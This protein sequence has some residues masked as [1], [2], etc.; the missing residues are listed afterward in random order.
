M[1]SLSGMCDRCSLSQDLDRS[2]CDNNRTCPNCSANYTLRSFGGTTDADDVSMRIYLAHKSKIVYEGDQDWMPSDSNINMKTF[3]RGAISV[4]LNTSIGKALSQYGFLRMHPSA[5]A[6]MLETERWHLVETTRF[7]KE[8]VK[9]SAYHRFSYDMGNKL[10]AAYVHAVFPL[11][12]IRDTFGGEDPKEEKLGD[13]IE[14]IL[15]LFEVWDSVPDCIPVDLHGQN[16]INELRRGLDCSLINFCSIGDI[17]IMKN[18]K[19]NKRKGI[20][21]EIPKSI[22]GI[23]PHLDYYVPEEEGMEDDTVLSDLLDEA[24]EVHERDDGDEQDDDKQEEEDAEMVISSGG[25]EMDEEETKAGEPAEDEPMGEEKEEGP[26]AKRRRVAKLVESIPNEGVCLACGSTEHAMSECK[27]QEAVKRIND[28]FGEILANIKVNKQSFPKG[29]RSRTEKKAKERRA[30][31]DDTPDRVISLYPEEIQAF[32]ICADYQD[33]HWTALGTHTN[34]L[35][36][37]SHN[38][39]IN[40]ILQGM[41][42]F[43][44]NYRPNGSVNINQETSAYYVNIELMFETGTLSIVPRNGV[45][46]WR[47]DFDDPNFLAPYAKGA[48]SRKWVMEIQSRGVIELRIETPNR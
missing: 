18:P 31:T 14:V 17:K 34:K 11:G 32:E 15:G 2:D 47:Q 25:E 43:D 26:E 28:A 35:G 37:S 12:F 46:Y 10:Y 16:G 6:R 4:L 44:R 39:V 20:T 7:Q 36:P 23:N 1:A 42:V 24:E 22:K 40:E 8:G 30:P 9:S 27:N 45:R 3:M 5:A 21:E 19:T 33:G 38:E 13:A 41:D 29:R 48:I